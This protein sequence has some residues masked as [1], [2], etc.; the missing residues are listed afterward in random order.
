MKMKL[1][2]TIYID[3]QNKDVI[4]AYPGDLSNEIFAIIAGNVLAQAKLVGSV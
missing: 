3:E 4:V 2:M 1:V